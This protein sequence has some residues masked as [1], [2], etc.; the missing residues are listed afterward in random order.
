MNTKQTEET[1]K[2]VTIP[3]PFAMMAS[4]ILGPVIV[5]E[6]SRAKQ[7]LGERLEEEQRQQLLKQSPQQLVNEAQLA[8]AAVYLRQQTEA[9]EATRRII[10]K[11]EFESSPSK[12]PIS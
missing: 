8:A 4:A 9:A 12:G 10:V 3:N 7:Y 1:P 6:I 2:K 5:A 11:Q